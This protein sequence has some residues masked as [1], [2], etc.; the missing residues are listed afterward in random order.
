MPT[1]TVQKV[2][3]IWSCMLFEG[4]SLSGTGVIE[5]SPLRKHF[6]AAPRGSQRIFPFLKALTLRFRRLLSFSTDHQFRYEK[7]LKKIT[8]LDC[9]NG[10]RK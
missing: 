2:V 7:Q 10:G 4:V 3:E 6:S 1:L 8:T 9:D 5:L